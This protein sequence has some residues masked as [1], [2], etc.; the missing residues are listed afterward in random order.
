MSRNGYWSFGVITRHSL[1]LVVAGLSYV[2][3]GFSIEFIVPGNNRWQSLVIARNV[4]PLDC[5]GYVF[6]TSGFLVA[7]LA[8]WPNRSRTWGYTILT[9]L[10]VG[11]SMMYFL[12]AFFIDRPGSNISFGF[13]WGLQG[14]VWWAISGLPDIAVNGKGRM[15]LW[16]CKESK[17]KHII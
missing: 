11:W 17:V 14:F 6:M 2:A 10:A 1:I 12:G 4:M 13:V 16:T 3:M 15:P 7:L 9:G 5:W 8:H